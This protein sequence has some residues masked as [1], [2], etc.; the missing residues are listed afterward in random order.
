MSLHGRKGFVLF[1]SLIIVTLALIIASGLI[2]LMAYLTTSTQQAVIREREALAL[3]S[4]GNIIYV[5]DPFIYDASVLPSLQRGTNDSHSPDYDLLVGSI[6][7]DGVN[8]SIAKKSATSQ[9]QIVSVS[10][11]SGVV[12]TNFDLLISRT[13]NRKYTTLYLWGLP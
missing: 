13:G 1:T 3:M 6:V 7:I 11:Q 5:D 9:Y 8:I 4:L 10:T 2:Y 12:G